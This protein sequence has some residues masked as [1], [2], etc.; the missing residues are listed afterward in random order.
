MNKITLLISG[1]AFVLASNL[2]FAQRFGAT[3]EDSAECI[4]NNS[5]YVEFYK[6]KQW[7]DAYEPWK[8]VVELCPKYHNN[9]Y[10]RG[11]AILANLYATAATPAEREQ[12]FN[13]MLMVCD[14][15][16]EAFGDKANN[17]ARKAQIY[18][19]YKPNETET[20]YNLYKEAAQEG[21]ANLD[22]QYCVLYLQAT[23]NYLKAIKANTEQM[24]V[25]FDVYDYASETM[26]G[27]LTQTSNDL[28]S[29]TQINDTKNMEK[30]QK[31]L[32]NTRSN[33]AALET[34]IEP[35]ASCEKIIPIYENRFN[36]N[37]TDL[38]LLKKIT[39]NLSRKDCTKSELFFKATENLHKQEPTPR[40]AFLMGQMLVGK[41]EY[42]SAAKYLEEAENTAED[43]STKAKAAY[44]LANAL[45][46]S[47]NY[48]AARTAARRA[49]GYDKSLAGK[50]TLLVANMYLATAGQNAAFAAYDEAARAKALDPSLAADA[51]RVMN[52]A[53]GR[54]PT[55]ENLFFEGGSAGGTVSVGGWIGGTATVRTR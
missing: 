12:Y 29:L 1:V 34:L 43:I 47:K 50:T 22:Q 35:F 25:L 21:G 33:I 44:Q 49:A 48:S 3:P 7:A 31:E 30:L 11:N 52:A 38:A 18:S 32:D 8:K 51:N 27:S 55:K 10:V 13:D 17:I 46:R 28:D 9:T 45:Y 24:S 4:M 41:E 20:I 36:N 53:H 19:Q 37:P 54:F 40:S 15:R 16:T 5:L 23:I 39:T 2:G 26:E 14:K 6:Q 42:T